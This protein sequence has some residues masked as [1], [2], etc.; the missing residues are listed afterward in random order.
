MKE[1]VKSS[2]SLDPYLLIE[3]NGNLRWIR[4]LTGC[5]F[6]AQMYDYIGCSCVEMVRTVLPDIVIFVDECGKIKDPPQPYAPL[7][8]KLYLGSQFG[9]PIVGPVIVCKLVPVGPYLELD[10]VPLSPADLAR[11][12]LFLGV[13]IPEIK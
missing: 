9:D 3:P 2:Q 13:P 12:S 5:C 1:T 10:C 11:L 7:A 4:L 8:S 6:C